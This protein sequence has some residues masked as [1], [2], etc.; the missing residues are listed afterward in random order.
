MEQI[1]G[2][3]V[4][5]GPAILVWQGFQWLKDG[6]WTALP[7]SKAVVYF[8][9]PLPQVNWKGLQKIIDSFLDLPASVVVF[10]LTFVLVIAL[11]IAEALA[12]EYL[13]K[14]KQQRESR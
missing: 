2:L 14:V 7:L 3:I 1:Y 5:V 4:L 12:T 9:W 8:G 6:Y 11:A 13:D 10:V